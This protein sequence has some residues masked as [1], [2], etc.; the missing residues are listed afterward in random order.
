MQIIVTGAQ[1]FLGSKLIAR[2]AKNNFDI[3]AADKNPPFN[4]F[5]KGV[6]YHQTDISNPA[7]LIPDYVKRRKF[8]LV[9]LAWNTKRDD[10]FQPQSSHITYLAGLLDYWKDKGLSYL[11][12]AG[13][14]EEYG[15][16]T[17][18]LKE[19]D[20]PSGNF[21]PYGW[22]KHAA[23]LLTKAWCQQTTIPAIWF[24]P[25][26][27]YGIGQKGQMLIP[28]AISKALAKEPAKFSDGLQKRDFIYVDDVLSAFLI[29]IRKHPK[30]FNTINLGTGH[31]TP[32]KDVIESI[33]AHFRV[34]SLFELGAI[35][36]K[37]NDPSIQIADVTKALQILNWR[38][39]VSIKKGLS[40]LYKEYT[41]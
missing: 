27:I 2:L 21:S 1:G 40:L 10:L 25:F 29:G 35:R 20:E 23:Y 26:T 34:Q 37:P 30:G 14:A 12:V 5:P 38:P 39:T 9:H 31:P 36:K 7:D 13:S 8:I 32:A 11:I 3:V 17:G 18:I 16:R 15:Q 4:E 22:S 24:R 41:K 33:A 28:Y 19:E 6:I